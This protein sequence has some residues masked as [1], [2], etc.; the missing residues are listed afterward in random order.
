MSPTA[1][2]FADIASDLLAVRK[3]L[4]QAV[5]SNDLDLVV[6]AVAQVGVAGRLADEAAEV[7]SGSRLNDADRW[8][9]SQRAVEALAKLRH[10]MS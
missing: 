2:L 9:H 7:L 6:A 1:D 4:E 5:L 3:T 10:A 8:V